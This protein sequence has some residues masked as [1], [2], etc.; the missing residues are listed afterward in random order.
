MNNN[1]AE[2]ETLRYLR[3][4]SALP[5][6]QV[7]AYPHPYNYSAINNFAAQH[8]NGD[9]L[10]M[11]NNDTEVTDGRWLEEMMRQAVRPRIGAV[12]AKL[13][14]N[15]GSIQHAGVVIG[16]GEAA[17]HAHRHL[18]PGQ[19]GYFARAHVTH[20]VSAVTAACLVIERRKF[21]AVGGLDEVGFAVAF[22]DVDLCLRLEKAGWRNIYTPRAVLIHHESQSRGKDT[23]RKHI[24]RYSAEL[25]LLQERWGTRDYVDPLHHPALDR[26]NESYVIKL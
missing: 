1:S 5:N 3:E 25:A 9:Y 17:G 13:L 8:C 20:F 21:E 14:Y 15:D 4:I 24:R 12:G 22:N 6:V 7:I 26:A 2:L 18:R 16:I 11:L 10:C 23:S 19:A